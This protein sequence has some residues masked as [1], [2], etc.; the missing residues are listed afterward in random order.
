MK[1]LSFKKLQT[2]AIALLVLFSVTV[3]AVSVTLAWF[4]PNANTSAD[5]SVDAVGYI[6][7]DF[8]DALQ[9]TSGT[10]SPAVVNKEA[11]INNLINTSTIYKEGANNPDFIVSGA[12]P[13]SAHLS[14]EYLDA[15]EESG[16]PLTNNLEI[17]YSVQTV[18]ASGATDY[19]TLTASEVTV[20]M[21]ITLDGVAV[22]LDAGILTVTG[23]CVIGFD[24][25]IYLVQVDEL[26]DPLIFEDGIMVLVTVTS[27]AE[28]ANA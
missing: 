22:Q 5:Y 8:D 24:F 19:I 23:D 25:E 2:L 7:L 12:T 18:H 21:N 27:H 1:N 13:F 26:T 16:E 20:D 17:G 28:E 10:L 4:S 3:T 15:S 14:L 9:T 11:V 6:V